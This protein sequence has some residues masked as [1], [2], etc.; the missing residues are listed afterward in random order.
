MSSVRKSQLSWISV[1][2]VS[3]LVSLPYLR[4]PT[5]AAENFQRRASRRD[6]WTSPLYPGAPYCALNLAV[7]ISKGVQCI[8]SVHILQGVPVYPR[9]WSLYTLLY[10][11]N[12]A[13]QGALF[14]GTENHCINSSTSDWHLACKA[15]CLRLYTFYILCTK[16]DIC[17][18]NLM[19][20]TLQLESVCAF[21]HRTM[22]C[23]SCREEKQVEGCHTC[24]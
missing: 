18:E 10:Q 7:H 2:L 20:F 3:L 24:Q 4:K 15:L 16:L 11:S 1:I 14:H 22:L 23:L 19:K 5:R 8:Y 21:C 13:V 6:P 17:M 9:L 12:V